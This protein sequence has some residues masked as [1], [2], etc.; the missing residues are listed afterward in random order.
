MILYEITSGLFRTAV[1][2][3]RSGVSELSI[4]F[5]LPP[6]AGKKAKGQ[7]EGKGWNP[8][9]QFLSPL[10]ERLKHWTSLVEDATKIG[11]KGPAAAARGLGSQGHLGS[12]SSGLRGLISVPRRGS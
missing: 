10:C 2:E 9:S 3:L 4:A 8:L 11:E 6:K 12:V 5:Y 1:T 7:E